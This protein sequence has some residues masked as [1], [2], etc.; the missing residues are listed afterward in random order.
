MNVEN[1]LM[2]VAVENAEFIVELAVSPQERTQGLSG[3]S[4][5]AP[6][7]GMLFIFES[8]GLHSFCM[9]DMRFPLDFVWISARC[10]VAAI[11]PNVPPPAPGKVNLPT[12]SPATPVQYVLE[13]N[14]GEA[15]SA[16]ISLGGPVKYNG[17]LARRYGC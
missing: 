4:S 5:L 13:I 11:T 2:V 15:E 6:G 16:G 8:E 7:T 9:E 17:G 1:A 14:S 3:R 12:Y 10:T